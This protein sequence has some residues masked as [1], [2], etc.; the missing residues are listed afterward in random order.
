M[1]DYLKTIYILQSESEV[2]TTQQIAERLNVQS[3]SVTNMVKRLAE[4]NL[5]EHTPYRGVVLTPS[6][7][8]AALE[9]LRHHRLLEL[10]LAE[11]LGYSWD[12]VHEEAD[13]LEH[14]ISEEFEAR[15]DRAL[16][17][18]TTDPHG[19]PIPSADGTIEQPPDL[20]LG[21]LEVGEVAI[22]NRVSDRDP[23]KLRYLGS[24]GLY[25]TVHVEVLE[26]FPFDGP[27]RISLGGTEHIL[28]RE[29]AQA[30]HV[31]RANS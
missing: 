24:L 30:V 11:A 1:E 27:I 22:V 28:G 29:L 3:P 12:E 2:V 26:R 20:R 7:E 8:K 6:G 10:Y 4:L 13:R 15:I 19:H 31:T 9:V 21:E 25:P 18:P 16:G 23:E 14:S 5:V 17:Y